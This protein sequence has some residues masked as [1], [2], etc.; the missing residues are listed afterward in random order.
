[1]PDARIQ[2]VRRVFAPG[3]PGFP[4]PEP[5]PCIPGPYDQDPYGDDPYSWI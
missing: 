4:P 2:P 3:F 1:M 5:E